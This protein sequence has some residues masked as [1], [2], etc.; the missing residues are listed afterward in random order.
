MTLW[1]PTTNKLY[2]PPASV[3]K[4]VSTD[5]IITRTSYFYHAST[6][7]LLTVGHPYF[8]I[9]DTSG[10]VIVPKVSP[11]QYRVFRLMLP[12][13]NKFGLPDTSLYDPDKERLVWCC[14]GVE[15]S[16]G[17]PLG[18]GLS[19]SPLFN[20]LEDT[21]NTTK[22]NQN[23]GTDNRQNISVDNKQTQLFILGC[24]PPTGEHWDKGLTCTTQSVKTGDCPPLEL[25]NTVIQ[26]GDMVDTG[27]GAM[28][29]RLLQENKSDTP[30]DI[31]QEICKYPDYLRMAAEPH[32]NQLFF[33]VR[34][35][36]MFARHFFC[37]AGTI[38]DPIPDDMLLPAASDQNQNKV[39]SSIYYATPSGSLVST[40]GQIFNRPFWLQRAQG[41]NNGVCWEN[42]LFV[43]VV[44]NTR[45]TN[46]TLSVASATEA[47][48]KST[49]FKQYL[50]HCEEYDIQLILQLCKV[51]LTPDNMAYIH[52]MNPDIL[53]SWNLGFNPPPSASLEDTYRYLTNLATR[54][55]DRV[56]PKEK[57][58]PYDKLTFWTVDLSDKVS[59]ELDQFP[60]G[61]KFVQQ[62]GLGR[63]S[64]SATGTLKRKAPSST[65]TAKRKRR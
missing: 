15:V 51:K 9:K 59:P 44:D 8:P 52:A 37:R 53:D 63:R 39:G 25:L 50:R 38:G 3:A 21:E 23:V 40:D 31:A 61:R 17:Q 12:D 18:V 29:F 11:N 6:S 64:T 22:Y 7:R 56:Q 41:H 49:N 33:F 55:P 19:G 60:L 48:Y 16:R 42:Q 65:S 24:V 43:T 30:L 1:V 10:T 58:D 47:T 20:R 26:D 28:N 54:C 36:Q 34:R 5:Q 45:G 4:V 14:V 46:L 13:P 62:T 32:G 2:L 35:E 27:F 57:V